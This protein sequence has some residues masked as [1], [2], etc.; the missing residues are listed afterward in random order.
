MAVAVSFLQNRHEQWS[1]VSSKKRARPDVHAVEEVSLK[2]ATAVNLM[3]EF[4]SICPVD[5]H[6]VEKEWLK[7]WVAGDTKID[8]EL[9]GILLERSDRLDVRLDIPTFKRLSDAQ[10]FARPISQP[11]HEASQLTIDSYNLNMKQIEYDLQ[12]FKIWV[13]KTGRVECARQQESLKWKRDRRSQAVEAA[14]LFLSSCS[15]LAVWEKKI[16]KSIAETMAFK[17]NVIQGKLGLDNSGEITQLVYFNCSAPCFFGHDLMG[18]LRP[19]AEHG[20][21]GLPCIRILQ[22]PFVPRREI[23]FGEA[24]PEPLE[25]GLAFLDPVHRQD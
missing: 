16:E 5:K 19:D 3:S 22:R 14:D 17:R 15:R 1:D 4:L 20:G 13:Q 10:V 18:A 2:A 7:A 9:D 6:M 25:F 21:A 8:V 23:H 24:C 12:V 11:A